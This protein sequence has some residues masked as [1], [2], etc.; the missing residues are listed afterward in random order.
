MERGKLFQSTNYITLKFLSYL[1]N[2]LLPLKQES[3][4]TLKKNMKKKS[5]HFS[6]NAEILIK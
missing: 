4:F 3:Y 6:E 1:F 5:W 2:I